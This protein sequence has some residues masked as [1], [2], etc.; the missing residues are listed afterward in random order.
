MINIAVGLLSVPQ[1]THYILDGVI[2]RSAEFP[3]AQD[4]LSR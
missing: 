3:E 2:W 1:V 4:G